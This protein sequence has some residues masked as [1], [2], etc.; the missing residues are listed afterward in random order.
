MS[1]VS[2]PPHHHNALASQPPAPQSTLSNHS[3][4]SVISIRHRSSPFF[5]A[6]DG[7]GT[8]PTRDNGEHGAQSPATTST[9]EPG[10]APN[11]PPLTVENPLNFLAPAHNTTTVLG[12]AATWGEVQQPSGSCSSWQ[13]SHSVARSAVD[14]PLRP[15]T[16]LDRAAPRAHG[17]Q[18]LAQLT[19]PALGTTYAGICF[20]TAFESLIADEARWEDHSVACCCLLIDNSDEN[21]QNARREA[22]EITIAIFD[23]L[24]H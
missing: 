19:R 12:A 13:T 16:P 15:A 10:E 6:Q 24:L 22:I 2:L 9:G 21:R 1:C 7:D 8:A 20:D 5:T 17:V 14:M 3:Q 18:L 4:E 23:S 11:H